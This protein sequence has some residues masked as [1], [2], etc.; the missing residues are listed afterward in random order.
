M[1]HNKK[2]LLIN[3]HLNNIKIYYTQQPILR[4]ITFI[5]TQMLPSLGAE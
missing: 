2:L 5:T 4:I 3:M 1:N